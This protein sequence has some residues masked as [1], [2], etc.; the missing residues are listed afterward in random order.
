[1]RI[2]QVA[3]AAMAALLLVGAQEELPVLEATRPVVS[4][5]EG[6]TLRKDA[7]R[8]APDVKPD[9]YEV[10]L[11]EG[12]RKKVTFISDIGSI[13]FDVQEGS[14]HE[15]IIRHGT[16]RC[17][18]R[19]VGVRFVPAAVFD[20]AYRAAHAGKIFVEVPEA[21]ELVNIAIA[22]TPTGLADRNL[23][24]HDSAYYKAMRAWF[25]PYRDHPVLAALD[26]ALTRQNGIYGSLK[27]NGYSFEFD[28]DG[29]LVQSKVY[30][31]TGFRGERSNTLRP[32][33]E[34]LEAFAR[35]SNFRAF[36]KK[37]L[38][39]YAE[40]ISFYQDEAGL[41]AMRAWL[42][43]NF[44][45]SKAYDCSKVIFSP[46]VAYS[47]SS[48]WLESNGFRELQAHVNYPYPQDVPRRTKGA[49]LSGKG[50]TILRGDIVFTE[51]NHG[52]IN[53]EADRYVDRVRQAISQRDHW[54][55]S[56]RGP[57]YYG[58]IAAFNEYM[59]WGLVS[60][61]AIDFAPRADQKVLIT[62]VDEMMTR[63][64]GFPRF[65]AF[66]AFLV[67][68]YNHRKP[69]QSIADLYPRIIDWFEAENAVPP[70]GPP[71]PKPSGM[72]RR[73]VGLPCQPNRLSDSTPAKKR[74][75]SRDPH[76]FTRQ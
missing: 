73:Q 64:R 4:I 61:R 25:D 18:T 8:L 2:T 39:I 12:E 74:S 56:G 57:N 36:Y 43:R 29:R 30:D 52:F 38:A 32:Y 16:D 68:L 62:V 40:Q 45:D 11:R 60:L 6:E 17:L 75:S 67:D 47:Q 37:N 10:Q 55:D 41:D 72:D 14:Q 19:I 63:R 35:D 34:Q 20:E 15:F 5:Q 26:K 9:I 24:Y 49:P 50:V 70:E 53:P 58:G 28:P 69:G 48:T 59:N 22:M 33:I 66:D 3:L 21:Y 27:M 1:V 51:L 46:L 42:E 23:V 7:W 31:R 76:R 65:A 54:V 13:S 71:T 44:P